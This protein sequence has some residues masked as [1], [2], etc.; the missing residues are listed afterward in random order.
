[1]GTFRT[2]KQGLEGFYIQNN[3]SFLF[4][5]TFQSLYC[6]F[7]LNGVIGHP[8]LPISINLTRDM[9]NSARQHLF[10]S[11]QISTRKT[12]IVHEYLN[13]YQDTL[14]GILVWIS[15][16][17]E[18]DNDGNIEVRNTTLFNKAKNTFHLQ[19][20]VV[21]STMYMIWN[22]SMLNLQR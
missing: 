15:L 17:K 22:Q 20:P 18:K 14:D 5:P 7:G 12:A 10:G 16:A 11:I 4:N 1:M 2:F 19:H 8:D 21:S 3:A 13:K 6:E 9:L